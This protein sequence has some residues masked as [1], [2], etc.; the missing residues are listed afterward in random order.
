MKG[1]LKQDQ[2]HPF[3]ADPGISRAQA[4]TRSM[5]LKRAA[6]LGVSVSAAG[7]L[8]AACGGS[9]SNG[10]SESTSGTSL[11]ELGE[12]GG[13]IQILTYAGY[14]G[15]DTIKPFLSKNGIDAKTTF[16]NN[17]DDVTTRLRSPAGSTADA[18]QLGGAQ[19]DIY[20]NLGAF[21]PLQPDWFSNYDTVEP[22]FTKLFKNKDGSLVSMPFVWGS[23]GWNYRPDLTD[24][25]ESWSELTESKFKGKIAMIDDPVS[26]IQT[27]ALAIGVEEPGRMTKDELAKT[28]EFLTK[29]KANARTVA[30]GYGDIADLLVA[31][32]VWCSFQGWN[33]VQAF[34]ADKGGEVLTGY[35]KEKS[36]GF[37]DSFGIPSE[38]DNPRTGTAF[39]DE[40]IGKKMQAY[41]GNDLVSGVV[42]LDVVPQIKGLG[43]EVFD[44]ND[45]DNIFDNQLNFALDAPIEPDGDIATH[46]EWVTAW[47]DVKAS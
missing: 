20:R 37:I 30:A 26:S 3:A 46:E 9:D 12:L 34:A 16:I 44:Y 25:I 19:V 29:V 8:I 45:F 15:G 36:V 4:M 40:M 11:A 18:A 41:V 1:P 5:F 10:S 43:A 38:S 17:Q 31:G 13:A 14:E 42:R 33:A 7:S 6:L 35:P 22:R 47:E 28:Q 32:D 27:G 24:P 39:I 2:S 23:L 21:K